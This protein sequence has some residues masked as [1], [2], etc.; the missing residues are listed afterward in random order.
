MCKRYRKVLGVAAIVL[1]LAAGLTTVLAWD[2]GG[3]SHWHLL[4][5]PFLIG[6]ASCAVMAVLAQV[7]APAKELWRLGYDAGLRDGARAMMSD[8]VVALPDRQGQGAPWN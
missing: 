5:L 3:D 1:S 8:R 7:I 4:Q 2:E 6:A